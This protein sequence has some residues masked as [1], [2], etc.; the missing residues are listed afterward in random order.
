MLGNVSLNAL[1]YVEAS[2][3]EV[4]KYSL[5]EEDILINTRNSYELVGK[6][7]I[8]K[9]LKE[10]ILFN[11]NLLRIRINSS[12]NPFFIFYQL[13][14]PFVR[15]QMEKHKK[16]TTS[17]CALYQRN[18]LPLKLKTTSFSNQSLIVQEIESRLSVA[19]KLAETIQTN[20]QK[21]EALRQSILKKAFEGRL[22][23]EA[24]VEA[25]RKEADWEPAERLL[26]R[27][28]QEKSKPRKS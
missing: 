18:I 16:A 2:L 24:E 13:I 6:A 22:L 11:N 7:G 20:L 19:D 17:V 27:I 21:S 4:E 9:N 15:N 23:S 14:A 25:C 26:E 8:V 28:K 10:K 3:E 1:V 5:N 12:Y